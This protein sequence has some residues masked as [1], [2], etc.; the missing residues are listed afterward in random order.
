VV[1]AV[2][3]S[4]TIYAGD[5]IVIDILHN[6]TIAPGGRDTSITILT[7]PTHGDATVN[8]NGTVSYTSNPEY[9]GPDS[10]RYILCVTYAN[11]TVCD[12]A[13]VYINVTRLPCDPPN[14]FSPNGDGVND[15]LDIP[16][17][18][19][20]P[21]ATIVIYNRWGDKVWDSK[22]PYAQKKWKGKN[23]ADKDLPEA[24]YYYTVDLHDGSK[25]STHYV[26]LNR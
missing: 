22:L 11:G 20:Y 17:L 16:C 15:E 18:T 23:D 1:I 14:G 10:F 26:M 13:W 2:N 4:G 25:P 9:Q 8:A 19:Q 7:N 5:P 3:D 6:D 21:N 24:T 12:T